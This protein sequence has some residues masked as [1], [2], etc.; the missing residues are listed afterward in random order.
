VSIE[1]SRLDNQEEGKQHFFFPFEEG[2]TSAISTREEE[3]YLVSV[4]CNNTEDT[5][6]NTIEIEEP[7]RHCE[8]PSIR[9]K[10]LFLRRSVDVLLVYYKQEVIINGKAQY[11]AGTNHS[12]GYCF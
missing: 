3:M 11:P 6:I 8:Q 12:I 1:K 4:S 7:C 9:Y 10:V 5:A 2:H